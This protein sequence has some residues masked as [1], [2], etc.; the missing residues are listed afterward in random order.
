MVG[1]ACGRR[2]SARGGSPKG[3]G[4]VGPGRRGSTEGRAGG[5]R[6][7]DPRR[8]AEGRDRVRPVR[9]AR[10]A[11]DLAFEDDPDRARRRLCRTRA[12]HVRGRERPG[13]AVRR[14]PR[15]AVPRGG[16][17]RRPAPVPRPR[18][19]GGDPLGRPH[20]PPDLRR[21]VVRR[22][23]A[24]GDAPPRVPQRGREGARDGVRAADG[25]GV[26]VLPADRG[27]PRAV[28]R[29]LPDLQ[30]PAQRL[31]P[32]DPPDRR[33]DARGRRGHHHG[34]LRVRGVAVGDQLRAG[35]R[36]GRA[37]PGVHLQERREGDREAGRLPRDVHEQAVRGAPPAAVATRTSRCCTRTRA[38]T[39][40]RTRAIRT[41]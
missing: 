40:S 27:H 28:V 34:E 4:P 19:R 13:F 10:H 31:R 41:G 1:K 30:H 2:P 37:R 35:A 5:E 6:R 17:V 26:R 3:S 38:R 16:R 12:Q 32:H 14:R 7:H 15:H 36:A 18:Q 39:R 25:L 22:Q 8:V 11:R 24:R 9:A 29:R 33:G 20:R 21:A 23:P